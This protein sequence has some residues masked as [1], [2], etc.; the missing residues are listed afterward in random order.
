MRYDRSEGRRNCACAHSHA[1]SLFIAAIY[2]F[3]SGATVLILP[4]FA[5]RP[6]QRSKRVCFVSSLFCPVHFNLLLTEVEIVLLYYFELHL[7]DK[8]AAFL[9]NDWG[10][11]RVPLAKFTRRHSSNLQH[12]HL[13]FAF[14][15]VLVFPNWSRILR[16]FFFP[17]PAMCYTTWQ[18]LPQT[19]PSLYR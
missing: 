8:N 4:S 10:H 15:F 13:A 3:G 18:T 1:D 17:P 16:P 19:I 5:L 6:R 2:C 12:Y 9:P 14:C 11:Y 7:H